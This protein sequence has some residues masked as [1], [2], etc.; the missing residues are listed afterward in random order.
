MLTLIGSFEA[1]ATFTINEILSHEILV[2][3]Q[4]YFQHSV[5]RATIAESFKSCATIPVACIAL[6]QHAIPAYTIKVCASMTALSILFLQ[7]PHFTVLWHPV[8]EA[9]VLSVIKFSRHL[10]YPIGVP[11]PQRE[12][13]QSPRC[14]TY[15]NNTHAHRNRIDPKC[16]GREK[17]FYQCF[18][19]AFLGHRVGT[20]I[21]R[22]SEFA[23]G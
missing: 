22:L 17:N 9:K 18:F 10:L 20:S 2:S 23:N 3:S 4:I 5:K 15:D 16:Q 6:K 8:V 13:H 12:R 19:L 11:S 14:H 1:S 21:L 7:A